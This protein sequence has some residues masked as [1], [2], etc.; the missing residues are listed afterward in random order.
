MEYKVAIISKK[1]DPIQEEISSILN[2]KNAEY[3]VLTHPSQ[4]GPE[5]F[6]NMF[7]FLIIALPGKDLQ[8]WLNK[9]DKDFNKFFKIYYYKNL[10]TIE[11]TPNLFPY[12][13]F[14][15]VGE[16][17]KTNLSRLIDFLSENYWKKIPSNWVREKYGKF[18]PLMQNILFLISIS[19]EENITL[20]Y[21]S[22]KLRV[23]KEDILK[24]IKQSSGMNFKQFKKIIRKHLDN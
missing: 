22:Q 1:E 13:D 8:I 2:K 23:D 18:H 15:V 14:I 3:F 9:L 6:D 19:K 11:P 17:R 4:S 12:F 10:S 24:E 16:Q 7:G 21:L 20:D 5:Y